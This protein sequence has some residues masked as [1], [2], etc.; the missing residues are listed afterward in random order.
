VASTLDKGHQSKL[1]LGWNQPAGFHKFAVRISR[2]NLVASR[3][4]G[5]NASRR[6]AKKIAEP[7]APERAV[8][9]RSP[10]STLPACPT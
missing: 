6:R 3:Q 2:W 4:T 10:L 7:C 8:R 1:A 9:L 5:I